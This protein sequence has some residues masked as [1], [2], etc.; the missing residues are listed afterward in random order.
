MSL[1]HPYRGFRHQRSEREILQLREWQSQERITAII[2][3]GQ[4]AE[5]KGS[6]ELEGSQ[7]ESPKIGCSKL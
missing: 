6:R 5:I 3:G 4:V 2:G 7:S 1:D